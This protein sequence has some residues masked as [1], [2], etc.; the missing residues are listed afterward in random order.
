[1][2]AE[3]LQAQESWYRLVYVRRVYRCTDR[4]GVENKEIVLRVE[5]RK[6]LQKLHVCHLPVSVCIR[7]SIRSRVTY[8]QV[9]CLLAVYQYT[10][11]RSW[12]YGT[13]GCRISRHVWTYPRG[14]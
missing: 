1:V 8:S 3:V 7:S 14:S 13:M 10:E 2:R 4:A 5:E 6:L 12:Y 11:C 9:P